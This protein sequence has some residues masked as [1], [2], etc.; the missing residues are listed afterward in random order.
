MFRVLTILLVFSCSVLFAQQDEFSYM[1]VN[2]C[3]MC[4]NKKDKGAQFNVWSEGPHA[5]AFETLKSEEA[6]KIA[7]ELKLE[8]SPHEAGECLGCHTTGWGKA[9][10]YEVL[11]ADFIGNPK[12]A[13]AVKK[14]DSKA[15]V[16][17]E[18]CHG[19]GSGYKSKKT[20]NGIFNGAIDPATVGL[21]APEKNVCITCHN[22][23]SPTFKKFDFDAMAAKIAHP[24]PEE[25]KATKGTPGGK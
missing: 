1:G 21:F 3:K 8:G 14:N 19:P 22:E 4:H 10:G 11:S 15:N 2:N 23:K 7:T 16:G 25:F 20:M 9:D 6:L 12:N 24:Y 5:R 18:T 13:R 17:C